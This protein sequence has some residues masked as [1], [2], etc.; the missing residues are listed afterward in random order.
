M[1]KTNWKWEGDE[2]TAVKIDVW[3]EMTE[4]HSEGDASRS[5]S[6]AADRLRELADELEGAVGGQ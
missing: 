2:Y 3:I 1:R 5:G 6:L 4:R